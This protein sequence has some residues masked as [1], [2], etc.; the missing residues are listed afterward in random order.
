MI[1]IL[2]FLFRYQIEE[3]LKRLHDVKPAGETYMHEGIKQVFFWPLFTQW[4]WG[5]LLFLFFFLQILVII[6]T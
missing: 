3:G 5:F 1:V 4:R 6:V 2:W